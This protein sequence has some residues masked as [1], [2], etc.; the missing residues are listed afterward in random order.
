MNAH[1]LKTSTIEGQEVC[2]GTDDRQSLPNLPQYGAE[3]VREDKRT[4][5]WRTCQCL[6]CG[7]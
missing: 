3:Q 6:N 4:V 1:I 2:H 5:I 7:Q